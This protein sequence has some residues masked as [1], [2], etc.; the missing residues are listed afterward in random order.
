M[1]SAGWLAVL[2]ILSLTTTIIQSLYVIRFLV[3]RP[4]DDKERFLNSDLT[5]LFGGL[6]SGNDRTPIN[7]TKGHGIFVQFVMWCSLVL[8][9][10]RRRGS[11]F[12]AKVPFYVAVAAIPQTEA[13]YENFHLQRILRFTHENPKTAIPRDPRSRWTYDYPCKSHPSISL[14]KMFNRPFTEIAIFNN[15]AFSYFHTFFLC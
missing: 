2:V 3:R 6:N 5:L 12:A 9:T 10:A 7:V 15:L 13:Y 4:T 1:E 14:P 8:W 11:C